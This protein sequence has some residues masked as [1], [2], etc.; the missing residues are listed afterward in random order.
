MKKLNYPLVIGAIVLALLTLISIY[1]DSFAQSDP[2]SKQRLEFISDGQASRIITPPIAPC[3]EYPWGTDH[4]GRDL[5]SLIVYGCNTTIM[6]ALSIA[7]GRLLISL[8]LAIAAAYKSKTARWLIKQFNILFSAFPLL[9]LVLLLSRIKLFAD[10][11]SS[12]WNAMGLLLAVLGWS[13]MAYMLMEKVKG[14]L[15]QDFIEGE[16]A[17]GKSKWEIAIQ[18]IIPHIIPSIIVLFFLEVA[19]VLLIMAQIGVF[20]IVLGGGYYGGFFGELKVPLQF[21]W[22]NLLSMANIHLGA[23]KLWLVIYPVLAFAV[24][25]IGFNLFGEGLRIEFDKIN[26]K[27]ITLIRKIPSTVSPVRFVYEIKNFTVYKSSVIKKALCCCIVLLLV[28]FP[29]YK[30][31]YRFS[32]ATAFNM[33]EEL[34]DEKYEGR[35]AG[36]ENSKKAGHYIAEKLKEYGIEPYE[37]SYFHS[38]NII[39]SYNVKSAEVVIKDKDSKVIKL[40]YRNDYLVTSIMP[41]KGTYDL[42]YV[43]PKEIEAARLATINWSDKVLLV[44]VRGKSETEFIQIRNRLGWTRPKGIVFVESW[45]SRDD[46]YKYPRANKYFNESFVVMLS[47]N[48]GNDIMKLEEPKITI[49]VDTEVYNDITGTN[50][51]GVIKGSETASASEYVILGSS[52]DYIGDDKEKRY[53]GASAAGGAALE[54]EIARVIKESGI[55]PQKTIIFAFWDGTYS[56]DRG[57]RSFVSNYINTSNKYFYM[58]LK[59][60]INKTANKLIM[61]TSNV[62]P[63]DK[64]A[65][66]AIKALKK[67]A[68]NNDI[69]LIFG[70]VYSPMRE[71]FMTGNRAVVVIDSLEEGGRYMTPY[72]DLSSIDKVKYGKVGQMITDTIMDITFGG[73]KK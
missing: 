68:H 47:S 62:L 30:N 4:L 23:G 52:L 57:S 48:M 73:I 20:S 36:S 21:D 44:D 24:S 35:L 55:I 33:L 27:I 6:L 15:D 66:D 10:I 61:D 69:D 72:D 12:Q 14:V 1:P 59:S 18:N 38:Y 63:K 37:G 9:I 34:S 41:V 71:D 51:I 60:F 70:R 39:E 19:M 2:Y 11:S 5:R 13:K 50:V 7:L 16:I 26:S 42:T 58:D 8:P 67:N 65:Q 31:P 54:L 29:Q 17:I 22:A 25:I 28:F 43:T 56:S 40:D 53:P 45:L 46:Y 3:K 32:S 49:N 64:I